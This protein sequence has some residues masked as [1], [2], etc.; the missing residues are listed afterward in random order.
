MI[1]AAFGTEFV[2]AV[3]GSDIKDELA[4]ETPLERL[5][6]PEDVAQAVW[7]LASPAGDFVTGQVLAPNGGFLI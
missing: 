5:G 4:E 6:T 7:F 1:R 2:V 3:I